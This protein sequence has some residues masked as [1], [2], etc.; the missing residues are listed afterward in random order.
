ML[1]LAE[2]VVYGI[3]W[4]KNEIVCKCYKLSSQKAEKMLDARLVWSNQ[5]VHQQGMGMLK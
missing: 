4:I 2:N 3:W 1:Q 5:P